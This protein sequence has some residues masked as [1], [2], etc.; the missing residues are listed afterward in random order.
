MTSEATPGAAETSGG[1]PVLYVLIP[2]VPLVELSNALNGWER[3][4]QTLEELRVAL[5]AAAWAMMDAIHQTHVGFSG[6]P[7]VEAF[8]AAGRETERAITEQEVRP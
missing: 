4:E 2:F 5:D 3:G 8:M 6:E 7:V 1:E